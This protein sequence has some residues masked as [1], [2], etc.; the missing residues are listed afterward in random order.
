MIHA[1]HG[2]A[3][4]PGDL[5]PLLRKCGYPHTAWH[6]W[7]CLLDWPGCDSFPGF[8]AAL[9]REI[10]ES[11]R[12]RVL[13]GYSMGAR[14]A[15]Q[16]LVTNSDD[17]DAAIL[18]SAHPGLA[19][20]KE[21]AERIATDHHWAVR[22]LQE[23][24]TEVMHD[25]NAQPVLAGESI[26][27]SEQRLV[28][29][30]R[31]EIAQAFHCWSLG[32]QPDLRPH[33]SDVQCPVLWITGERDRKFSTLAASCVKLLPD[34]VHVK[35]PGAGHRVHLDQPDAATQAIRKFLAARLPDPAESA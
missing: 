7:R 16:C 13:L 25:W 19:D 15:L 6:L 28:E 21:K 35:I 32:A 4:Q 31:R 5:F 2:M 10:A 8:A 27:M 20:E 23:P 11:P 17:W 29:L 26:V 24:W 1:L 34:A 9:H 3:G 22:F 30:W 14:L 18:I 33:L 12:P